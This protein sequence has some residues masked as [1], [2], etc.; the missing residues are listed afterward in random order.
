[1]RLGVG[2]FVD[3][4]DLAVGA[5]QHGDARWLLLIWTL[6][7]A[8]SHSDRTVG[9]GQKIAV[10]PNFST[11]CLQLFYRAESNSQQSRVFLG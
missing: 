1:M 11:P 8:I 7:R 3:L 6:G 10:E 5:D 4:G 9:V 2:N